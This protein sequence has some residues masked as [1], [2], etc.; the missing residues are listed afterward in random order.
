[1]LTMPTYESFDEDLGYFGWTENISVFTRQSLEPALN[2]KLLGGASARKRQ[3]D[4]LLAKDALKMLTQYIDVAPV[5]MS[6]RFN[7]LRSGP[8]G[9]TDPFIKSLFSSFDFT[10]EDAEVEDGITEELEMHLSHLD[11][12]FH[13]DN[14]LEG[15]VPEDDLTVTLCGTEIPG[16]LSGEM[17]QE[18]SIVPELLA[19]ARKFMDK[20]PSDTLFPDNSIPMQIL[21][22]QSM[23]DLDHTE[24]SF[25]Y[26]F[27]GK[28]GNSRRAPRP[29]KNFVL[30][31][32]YTSN[33]FDYMHI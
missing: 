4:N 30:P 21:Y 8:F 9:D 12:R 16:E 22:N 25:I 5:S 19:R 14:I 24:E 23:E 13:Q 7:S 10:H 3:R 33:S 15:Y 20:Y 6:F 32:A 26:E 31:P 2:M 1:M 17:I 18:S 28:Y 27:P 11:E 29:Q